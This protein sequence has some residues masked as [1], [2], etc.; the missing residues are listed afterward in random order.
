[1]LCETTLVEADSPG[2]SAGDALAASVLAW[3]ELTVDEAL[4][5]VSPRAP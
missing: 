4:G 1:M 5:P 3:L 2:I